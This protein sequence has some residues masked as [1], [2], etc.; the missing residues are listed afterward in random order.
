MNNC[1]TYYTEIYAVVKYDIV[2]KNIK[3]HINN[4]LRKLS[5]SLIILQLQIYIF[6][7]FQL[8]NRYII[9]QL[10]YFH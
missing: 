9:Y 10:N 4:V 2:S 5:V 7:V 6:I 1:P 3:M 8:V